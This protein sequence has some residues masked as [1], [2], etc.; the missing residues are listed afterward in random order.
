MSFPGVQ[1]YEHATLRVNDIGA[2]TAFCTDVLGLLQIAR[3]DSVVYLGCGYNDCYDVAL[4]PGGVGVAE[5]A[6]RV[7]P[8]DLEHI[9]TSEIAERLGAESRQDDAPGVSAALRLRLPSGHRM[10]FVV[11]T[12]LRPLET[13]RPARAVNPVAPLDADHI[14]L[15][16]EDVGAIATL[17]CESFGM[18]ASDITQDPDSAMYVAAW[19]RRS[20]GHH[21]VGILLGGAGETLHH[22]AFAYA[23]IDHIKTALD[24][25]SSHGHRLEIGL[26]RHPVGANLFAYL[27]TPGGNRIEL[28]AEGVILDDNSPTRT[29]P[30]MNETMNAWSDVPP[31]ESFRHGS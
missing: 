17:L 28:C 5:F 27:W 4:M 11:P 9:A 6:L 2:A 10:A 1:A 16:A 25:L 18:R 7:S 19:L 20:S 24:V 13:Y 12:D 14:N 22:I 21:D 26:G 29:W 3:E 30:S 23:G 8:E 31:P 15:M